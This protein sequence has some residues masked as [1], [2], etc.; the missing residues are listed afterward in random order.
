MMLWSGIL[1]TIDC[2]KVGGWSNI[3][4]AMYKFVLLDDTFG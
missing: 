2:T 1:K 3:L 4:N